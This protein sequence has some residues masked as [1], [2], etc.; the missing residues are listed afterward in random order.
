M[1]DCS[2][3]FDPVL[4]EKMKSLVQAILMHATTPPFGRPP[5]GH[6][7]DW[8]LK[9]ARFVVVFDLRVSLLLSQHIFTEKRFSNNE[10]FQG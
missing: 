6:G 8:E 10:D 4:V 3:H 1:P 2:S 5:L 9:A 7:D